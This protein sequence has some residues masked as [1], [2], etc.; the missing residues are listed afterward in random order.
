MVLALMIFGAVQSALL[1]LMLFHIHRSSRMTEKTPGRAA[2]AAR[3][4]M[5]RTRQASLRANQETEP[6]TLTG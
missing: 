5:H 2:T 6:S 4:L 1:L 3:R